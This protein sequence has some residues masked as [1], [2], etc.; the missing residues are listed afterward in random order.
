MRLQD[1]N[2]H[3]TIVISDYLTFIPSAYNE[4]LLVVVGKNFHNVPKDWVVTD[5]HHW[6]RA[7]L[8][9]FAHSGP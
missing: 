5:W 4:I 8:S 7:I 3:G 2:I 9:F 6:F 1:K